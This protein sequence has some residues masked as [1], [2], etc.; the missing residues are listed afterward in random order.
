MQQQEKYG[1]LDCL[2]G[3]AADGA[4]AASQRKTL[5]PMINSFRIKNFRSCLDVSLDGIGPILALAG[6]NGVGKTNILEGIDWL[7]KVATVAPLRYGVHAQGFDEKV[8]GTITF[9][10]GDKVYRYSAETIAPRPSSFDD[11][12]LEIKE[13]LHRLDTGEPIMSRDKELVRL[14]NGMLVKVSIQ[15]PAMP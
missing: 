3:L 12:R 4:P 13:D 1:M 5:S 14:A 8:E 10:S 7:A 6:Q 15:S 2:N 9:Q 11:V